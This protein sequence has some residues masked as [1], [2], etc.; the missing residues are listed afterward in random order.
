MRRVS[1]YD[2]KKF[3]QNLKEYL[4]IDFTQYAPSILRRRLEVFINKWNITD[5]ENLFLKLQSNTSLVEKLI[6]HLSVETT[7][8]F[9]D[10]GFWRTLNKKVIP[11]L[12]KLD[13]INILVP[14]ITYDD[15]LYT[16]L[17]I[18]KENNL[19]E[20]TN[21]L[22]TSPFD[23]NIVKS[24]SGLYTQKKL[25]QANDNYRRYKQNEKAD[26][27]GYFTII[28]NDV[29]FSTELI[30]YVKFEKTDLT[31]DFLN[32]D[33]FNLILFRN[34]MIYFNLNLQNKI[35][36]I[37]FYHLAK[38]GY[39][40]IGFK[41]NLSNFIFLDKLQQIDNQEKIFIKRK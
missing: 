38:S 16:L 29:Q 11:E 2:V 23:I 32:S 20:K 4:D 8:M 30:N 14:Y 6:E 15:E 5:L 18:L 3:T 7:E 26:I 37:L 35:L 33:E 27:S 21:I 36:E 9:R 31:N 40:T 34:R 12:A 41:E 28:N 24:R 39:L 13:K 22:A 10:P 19:L 17:V 1:T 25:S